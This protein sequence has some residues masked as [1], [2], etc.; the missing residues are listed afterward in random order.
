MPRAAYASIVPILQ[1]SHPLSRSANVL[2]DNRNRT[3][4]VAARD[5]YSHLSCV[6]NVGFSTSFSTS[7]NLRAAGGGSNVPP[8]ATTA[9]P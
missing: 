9:G 7:A 2:A 5:S 8:C 1:T 6:L 3:A 4:E